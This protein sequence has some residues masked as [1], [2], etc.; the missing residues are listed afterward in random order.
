[1]TTVDSPM[2]TVTR[3]AGRD[4][5]AFRRTYPDPPETVWTALTESDR[6]ARWFGSFTGDARPGGTVRLTMTAPE[7]AG[8][9]PAAVLIEECEPHSRLRV[10]FEED[11]GQPWVISVRLAPSTDGTVLDFHQTLPPGISP[12]DAGP[13]WHWYLDRLGAELA[14]RTFPPWPDYEALAGR[15]T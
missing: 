9:P 7:D 5:L 14:G 1:M 15:Y 4:V 12:A 3:E 6:L 2:G 10:R 11:D 8:G 13:G